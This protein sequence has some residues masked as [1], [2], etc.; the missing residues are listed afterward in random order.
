MMCEV[1][2]T[3]SEEGPSGGSENHGSGCPSQPDADSHFEQHMM[4]MLEETDIAQSTL[5]ETQ[6]TLALTQ[7]KLLE[8]GHE[9]DSL[10]RQLNTALPQEFSTLAKELNI[11][12]E[13]LLEKEKEIAELKAERNNTRLFL[14]HL[15]FLVSRHE[16][17]LETTVMKRQAR[18][19][20]DVSTEME[21][22]KALTFLFDHHKTLD[23]EVREQ[24]R[25][26]LQRCSL[27]EE[28]LGAMHKELMTLKKQ[29]NEKKSPRDG[30]LDH[31]QEE[32]PSTN[33]KLLACREEERDDKTT[34]KCGTSPLSSPK[35]LQ[36]DRLHTG[37]LQIVS[38]EDI[39]D[40]QKSKSA[41]DG[42]VSNPSSSDSRQDSPHKAP[43]KKGIKSSIGRLFGKK[44]K[45][46]PGQTGKESPGQETSSQDAFRLSKLGRKAEKNQKFGSQEGPVNNPSTSDSRQDALHK[47]PKKKSIKSSTGRL[48]GKKKKGPPGQ[49]GKES[50]RQAVVSET[51]NSSQDAFQLSKLGGKD[52]KN[53][54]LQKHSTG[55]QEG[56]VNNP[57]TSDSRQDALHKAPKKKSIKSST[58]RLFG[59]KN[60]VLPGQT[61]KESPRQA[62]VSE[63]E[64]SSQDAFQL[65]KLGGKDEKNRQLQKHSTGSQEGPVNNPSTSDSRQDALHK[66]PKKKS[67]K[68]STGRLFGKKNKVLPGQT[69]R[70]SPRQAVVS[71]TENS[72]QDAFQLSKLGGKDEKNHQLQKH[73][74]GSQDGPVSVPSSSDSREDPLH[75]ALKKK[76]IKSSTGRLFAKKEKGPPGQ[77]GKESPRQAVVSEAENSSQ[78]AFQLS[79]LGGK[80]E[81]NRQLQKQPELLEEAQRQGLPFSQWDGPTVV[82]WLE[83]W[84]GMPACYVAACRANVKSG[85]IMSALSDR[86][87]QQEIGI[88]HPLHRLK[89]R[90]AIQETLWLTSPSA[91]PTLKKTTGNV[92]LTHEEMETLAATSQMED[93]EGSWIQTLAYGDMDHEWIGNEWLPSLGLPQYRSYFMECLVDARMLDHLTRKD[94]R[95][96]LKMVDS[97]HRNSFQ[98]G[99]M[100]LKRLNYD[101]K[102]LERRREES[103]HVVKDVLVWSNDR[104]IRWVISIGLKEYAN[105]LIE[106]GVHG[107]Q[108]AL[109][110]AFDYNTLAL[111]LQIPTENRKARNV[112]DKEFADLLVLGT[113][114]RFDVEHDK[115][116]RRAP[117]WREKVREKAIHGVATG[118][119]ETLPANFRVSSSKSS[120]S[121][122]P[123]EIQMDG[124]VS[125]TQKLDSATVRTSSR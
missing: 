115:H 119:S 28:E 52:E 84:V 66:A 41:Q 96:R 19:P 44:E 10:Q 34:I 45:G 58:G 59:K 29:N 121:V 31:E 39:R 47:A 35:S 18:C 12:R 17:S 16:R 56:P 89:L 51:E 104:V 13:Q 111:L 30:V 42:P 78:D 48:F 68:S 21:V 53:R 15:E 33:G 102:E 62:V 125:E 80:D 97:F 57:S 74:I 63:T 123:N 11:C 37:A 103:Q 109:D 67:I 77:T 14:E 2:P 113:V 88:S 101:R 43:K 99:L 116:F 90:L 1:M 120:H 73:S 38:H 49:T 54:Q 94:L 55:S 105:N 26:A 60:K 98:C 76:S 69:G 92:W 118:S 112:L 117:S 124:S 100:C 75:K 110:E 86:Q 106:S 50:P 107:A 61:G 3:I 5:I 71:E 40:M 82:E 36:L 6:E 87:I 22:L 79:K 25:V 24:L 81:K 95:G 114:R 8:V 27:L 70:E 83:L 108:L 20:A 65:S 32:T 7:G 46:R 4:S 72:S 93:E 64:N 91:P 122:Q 85:A 23:K 9:R